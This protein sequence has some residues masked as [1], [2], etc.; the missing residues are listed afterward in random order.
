MSP[1]P[2]IMVRM[3]QPTDKDQDQD[4]D[5]DTYI[6]GHHESV[7]RSHRWRTVE[8][9]ASYLLPRLTPTTNLLDVGC[10]PGTI[11]VGIA[12]RVAGGRV[13]GIDTVEEILVEARAEAERQ[14]CHN[15]SFEPGD[16]YRLAYR[17]ASFDVVHAHQ[18]LQHLVDPVAA[19]REMCRVCRSGGTVA[20]RDGDY[21]AMFWYP[22]NPLLEDWMDLYHQVAAANHVEADAGRHLPEWFRRAGFTDID[23]SVGT[24]CYATREEQSWWGQMWADRATKSTFA[25][26]ATARG[27]ATQDDLETIASAWRDWSTQPDGMFVVPNV[28]VLGRG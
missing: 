12:S 13:V 28:E 19:L 23:V 11:T 4:R 17:D 20:A 5:T 22:A 25:T 10:G 8:N 14:D 21:G 27:L 9:S 15:V 1:D 18:V 16:V 26:Q 2:G 3:D 7:L 24:Y 6:H